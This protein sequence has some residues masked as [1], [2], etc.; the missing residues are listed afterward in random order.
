MPR[1]GIEPA[2]LAAHAP[3]T[4][5]STYSATWAAAP[6]FRSYERAKIHIK[7]KIQNAKFKIIRGFLKKL[8]QKLLEQLSLS[9]DFPL[10]H[11]G[12]C[13]AKCAIELLGGGTATSPASLPEF[14][15]VTFGGNGGEIGVLVGHL[16]NLLQGCLV[17][18]T[19]HSG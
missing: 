13:F 10:L 2:R 8:H 3:E 17:D 15:S 12:V 16:N 5:A 4:C 14:A 11:N 7:C 19:Q 9:L 1:T 6:T 18:V